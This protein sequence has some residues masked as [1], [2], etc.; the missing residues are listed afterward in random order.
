[1]ADAPVERRGALRALDAH[2]SGDLGSEGGCARTASP[3]SPWQGQPKEPKALPKTQTPLT[4]AVRSEII[5]SS[6]HGP[7]TAVPRVWELS[8]H[9]SILVSAEH[10]RRGQRNVLP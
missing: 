7:K 4:Q 1:M 3:N 8:F 6:R 5:R 2:R 10:D 9:V